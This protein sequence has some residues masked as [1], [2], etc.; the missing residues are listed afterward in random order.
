M[1]VINPSPTRESESGS[2]TLNYSGTIANHGFHTVWHQSELPGAGGH[3]VALKRANWPRMEM[4]QVKSTWLINSK[5]A[6]HFRGGKIG[7]SSL[8]RN[9]EKVY[10]F[11]PGP[12]L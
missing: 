10:F 8:K 9:K 1:A 3:Q 6:L 12:N 4:E 2:G 7:R 11:F 5:K